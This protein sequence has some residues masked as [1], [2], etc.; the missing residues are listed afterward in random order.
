MAGFRGHA[1]ITD[2]TSG[3]LSPR[4]HARVGGGLID[5]VQGGGKAA[6]YA[7]SCRDITNLLVLPQG[8]VA[9]RAGMQYGRL[10]TLDLA[11]GV[12]ADQLKL[13]NFEHPGSDFITLWAPG[14]VYVYDT[15]LL[16][17]SVAL[18][19]PV[20]TAVTPY[21]L[22]DVKSMQVAQLQ[23]ALIVFTATWRMRM[24]RNRDG[25]W[26]FI[27]VIDADYVAPLYDFRD[28]V[29]P[30][31]TTAKF[32]VEFIVNQDRNCLL[33]VSNYG[34][35]GTF[36]GNAFGSV[37][38][39]RRANS[40]TTLQGIINALNANPAVVSSSIQVV[41]TGVAAE[42]KYD[43]E[44]RFLGSVGD[45]T[46]QI[47]FNIWEA[48][49]T[50]TADVT[51][52]A[53]GTSGAEPLWSGPSY[54]LHNGT[55]YHCILA[56][57]TETLNEPGVGPNQAT[58][59]TAIGA[60]LTVGIDW[61]A[62][63]EG[64]PWAVD[65]A[66]S[67]YD[68]GWPTTG[69]A[70]EQRL[71]ANGPPAARGV[72]AGSRTGTGRLLNFTTGTA[73]DDGFVFL[74]V[75]SNGLS[76]VWLHS[77]KLLYVGTS[78]GVYIQ[79]AVP[80]TP[81]SVNFSRQSNYSLSEYRAFDVAGEV[82]YVQRNGR[83]MRRMQYVSDLDSYQASD[84]TA[85]A[86]HLFTAQYTIVDQAY[87]NSPDTVLWVLRSDGGLVALTYER[88]YGVAAWSKHATQ[89]RITA[90]EPF[91]GGSDTHDQVAC[92]IER[93][94]QPYIE[95]MGDSSRNEFNGVP[96]EADGDWQYAEVPA[97]DW[98]PFLDQTQVLVG[99]G[100]TV[101]AVSPRFEG[102]EVGVVEDGMDLGKYTVT[103]G[104][105][106][107]LAATVNGSNIYVG[108]T[109]PARI[110]PARFE[111]GAALTSQSQKIR[112]T[113]PMLRLFAS[114]IPT[115]NGQPLRERSQG[116]P[117]DAGTALFTG[118]VEASNLGYDGDLVIE[119]NGPSPFMLSGIFG[120]LTIDGG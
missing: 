2:F 34:T 71:V 3:E 13:F 119:A 53:D 118:D 25:V 60:T 82:F 17:Y 67:P 44:Y 74:L 68:R 48:T 104:N 24:L 86:E 36:G 99:N 91:F 40:A 64:K 75:G 16:N 84:M 120:V 14:M 115:V 27:D 59:W 11:G 88:F 93:F 55:Y 6:N 61:T 109:Y 79:T 47:S 83:Q 12:T 65:K 106:S 22:S 87:Q 80:I 108:Y 81:T 85:L 114:T 7:S 37:F 73:P 58:Y 42:L 20:F 10:L 94:G 4:W 51:T 38:T 117:Y 112:W 69:T 8:G 33:Q 19:A 28:T 35:G 18:A 78:V 57:Y 32:S 41:Y 90:I 54:V 63:F 31:A 113:R 26:A 100:T 15:S 95:I 5:P 116:D 39:I 1:L 111:A 92:V 98:E 46:G 101:L 49:E 66:A 76:I 110:V 50:E 43:I 23:D 45:G 52:T 97:T 9:K 89:G 96:V 105:I 70:H 77:Q 29:S 30:P 107:L 62:L 72:V 102:R 56:H 21:T 103:G